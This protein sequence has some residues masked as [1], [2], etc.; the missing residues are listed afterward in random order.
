MS[1]RLGAERL[2]EI[3]IAFMVGGDWLGWA[4]VTGACCA[5]RDLVEQIAEECSYHL[6]T[7]DDSY[8]YRPVLRP[9]GCG[10]TCMLCDD[11]I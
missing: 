3:R 2:A 10:G 8:R 1:V 5:D 7:G 11:D 6:V 9:C 4:D